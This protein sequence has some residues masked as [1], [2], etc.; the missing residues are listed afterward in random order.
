MAPEFWDYRDYVGEQN[1]G[2]KTMNRASSVAFRVAVAS[3]ILCF[4][5][6]RLQAQAAAPASP[7]PNAQDSRMPAPAG[8]AAA[9]TAKS[10]APKQAPLLLELTK[11]VTTKSARPGAEAHFRVVEDVIEDGLLLIAEGAEVVAKIDGVD[12]HAGPEKIPVLLARFGTVKT[13]T[14]EQLPIVSATGNHNG[15]PE[16]LRM[17]FEYLPLGTRKVVEVRLPPEFERERL[18]AARP[19]PETPPGFA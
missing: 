13:V 19:K 5:V 16:K 18:L 17:K 8:S 9:Q 2:G 6:S 4:G 7:V 12:K 10:N 14:G 3:I 15:E 1:S 11:E